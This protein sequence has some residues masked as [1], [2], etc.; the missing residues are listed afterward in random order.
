MNIYREDIIDIELESGTVTRSFMNKAIGE[1]DIKGNRYGFRCLRNGVPISLNGSTIIGHFTRADGN[2]IVISGGAVTGDTA[3]ITLPEACYAVEGNFTLAIKLISGGETGTI[4]IV[5][6]TVISTT[7][8]TIIDPG[9]VVPDLSDY[10]AA[11][12]AAEDAAE[13][14]NGISITAELISGE[15]Y[16]IIVSKS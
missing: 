7:N 8:G 11:V 4:R 12:E 1:G 5:D 9:N 3:F 15:D 2:T 14:I 16:N 6:G 10:L 13:I